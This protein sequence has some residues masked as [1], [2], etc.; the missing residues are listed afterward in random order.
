MLDIRVKE[1]TP[2]NKYQVR[3]FLD[4]LKKKDKEL[5]E[6][7]QKTFDNLVLDDVDYKKLSKEIEKLEIPRLKSRHIIKIIDIF[8]QDL[9]GLSALFNGENIT[10]NQ[11]SLQKILSVI[12]KKDV[13]A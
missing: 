13:K 1:E 6:R 12:P 10:L 3:E 8:P 4:S 7:A 11:E 2:I 9:E 5:N